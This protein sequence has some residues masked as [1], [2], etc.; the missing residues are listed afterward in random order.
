[1]YPTLG[2]EVLCDSPE[3]HSRGYSGPSVLARTS[4]FDSMANARLMAAAPDLLIALV[5][6]V[7]I[8][9]GPSNQAAAKFPDSVNECRAAIAKATAEN[10]RP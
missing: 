9:D 4:D 6:M 7:A 10:L 3:L 5:H 8:W 1:M 2:W